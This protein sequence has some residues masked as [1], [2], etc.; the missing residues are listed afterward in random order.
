MME[1]LS[2]LQFAITITFH[3]I[4]PAFSI[5]LSTYILILELIWLKTNKNVYYKSIRFWTKILALTFGM[6]IISG[7]SMEFQIGTNWSGFSEK[8]GPV[9]GVLFAL[10]GL[11]A[12][13]IEAT[14]LG[15]M[16]FGWHHFSK[17]VHLF[18]TF[19]VFI[20]VSLS[21]FWILAAN[22]WMQTPYGVNYINGKFIVISWYG[23]IFNHSTIIRYIHMMLASYISTMFVVASI[24]AIYLKRKTHLSFA[25]QNFKFSLFFIIF[26][27]AMQVFIGDEVGLKVH[28]YQPIKTAAIEGLWDSKKGAPLELFTIFN[29]KEQ[30]NTFSI[31]IPYVA[32]IINTHSLDGYLQGLKS[33]PKDQIPYVPLVFYS[34]RVMVSCGMFMVLYGLFGL[35]L[36]YSKKRDLFSNDLFLKVSILC[37]PIGFIALITGWY[38]AECGRQ[39]WVV[40]GYLSTLDAV[41]RVS[42]LKVLEG[43]LI[44]LV[45]YGLIFGFGY[46]RY[47]KRLVN[48]GPIIKP[49]KKLISFVLPKPKIIKIKNKEIIKCII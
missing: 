23:V 24:S 6:G 4:F 38:T 28:E 31:S 15:I 32:S 8:V 30:K 34:F 47:L 27:S 37:A 10:E 17:K 49:R 5:G 14:F 20:G 48:S 2:R 26:L 40:Y 16:L 45:I 39:P 12:F 9:L 7:L 46:L 33:V 21:A 19:M 22:S 41:S 44:I 11:S 35:Y 3:I 18:S 1:L 43:F 25:K 13:F 29:T 36:F 42:P